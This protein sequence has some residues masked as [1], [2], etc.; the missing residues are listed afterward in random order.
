M[1]TF[2]FIVGGDERHY[3]NLEKSIMSIRDRV[4][5]PHKILVIDNDNIIKSNSNVRVVHLD[6]PRKLQYYWSN[7]YRLHEFA[8]TEYVMYMDTDTVIASDRIEELIERSGDKFF[9][10]QHW[11]VKDYG[12]YLRMNSTDKKVVD[13]LSGVISHTDPYFASGVFLFNKNKN[14]KVFDEYWRIFNL[15]YEQGSDYKEGITDEFILAHALNLTGDYK[16]GPGSLNHCCEKQLMPIQYRD[17]TLYGSNPFES[18][19]EKIFCLHCD[20]NRRDPSDSYDEEM[21]K[22]IKNMFYI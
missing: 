9:I 11:W 6:N 16:L 3:K 12:S 22:Y 21:S 4:K 10:C 19:V 20:T 7:R 1:I 8:E 5:F 17:N 18:R 13:K 15:C 14:S 2:G